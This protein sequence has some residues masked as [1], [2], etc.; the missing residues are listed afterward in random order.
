V[1]ARD[2]LLIILIS[3]TY[4]ISVAAQAQLLL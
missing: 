4:K 3:E 2:S 1:I